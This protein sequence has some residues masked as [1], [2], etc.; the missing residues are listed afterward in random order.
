MRAQPIVGVGIDV[1]DVARLSRTM[2]RTK[3][4]AATVFT[5]GEREWCDR[6]HG[7]AKHYAGSFAAKEAFLKAVGVG[8][9]GGVSLTDV[10]V[11]R[12][13]SG[14]PSLKL[15]ARARRAVKA[16]GGVRT[17]ISLSHEAKVAL[18]VVLVQ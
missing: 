10:E 17:T 8:L 15:A 12:G 9:W 6:R 16:C 13:P 4:F 2:E 18:A 1:V 5:D 14:R 3:G 7:K 11:V